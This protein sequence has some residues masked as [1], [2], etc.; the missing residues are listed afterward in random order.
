MSRALL[1]IPILLCLSSLVYADGGHDHHAIP[2]MP[3]TGDTKLTIDEQMVTLTFGPVDLRT[4]HDGDLA[5]SMPRKVFQ[6]P[7]D[8]YMIGYK[9]EV[10]T[11]DGQPLPKNYPI[12]F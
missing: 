10:F 3:G 5:A 1:T 2:T 12:T 7:E 11:K 9:S 4:A 6:L 8:T